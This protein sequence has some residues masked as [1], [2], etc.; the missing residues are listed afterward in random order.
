MGLLQRIA[1][2]KKCPQNRVGVS[3]VCPSSKSNEPVCIEANTFAL[4]EIVTVH[5]QKARYNAPVR[6][7]LYVDFFA[8]PHISSACLSVFVRLFKILI[9]H[10]NER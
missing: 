3:L 2:T 4:R 9:E 7:F 6:S 10:Q 5:V 8:Q 1:P